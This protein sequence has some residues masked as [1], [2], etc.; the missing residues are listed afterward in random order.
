LVALVGA[1]RCFERWEQWVRL[2]PVTLMVT[3][4]VTNLPREH[5][6]CSPE[7]S[8]HRWPQDVMARGSARFIAGNT[9][10]YRVPCCFLSLLHP[11]TRVVGHLGI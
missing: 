6:N 5:R 9:P 10:L 3:A 4:P 7:R 2:V 1:A 8:V 11:V